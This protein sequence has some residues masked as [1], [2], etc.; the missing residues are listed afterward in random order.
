MR[1]AWAFNFLRRLALPRAVKHRTLITL[2]AKF[3]K[4]GAK[5]VA[6]ARHD[7]FQMAEVAIS[8]T[9]FAAI[10]E[11]IRRLRRPEAGLAPSG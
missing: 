8:R 10:L 4:I 1:S 7:I 6:H 3:V 11:R 5:V 2:R 9:I